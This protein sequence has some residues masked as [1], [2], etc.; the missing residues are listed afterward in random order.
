MPI[1]KYIS[2]SSGERYKKS[3]VLAQKIKVKD[4]QIQPNDNLYMVKINVSLSQS[5]GF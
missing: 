1:L 4:K 2:G 3:M 5:F